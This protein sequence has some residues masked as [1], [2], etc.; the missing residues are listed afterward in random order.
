MWPDLECT[1]AVEADEDAAAMTSDPDHPNDNHLH[2][3]PQSTA[4]SPLDLLKRSAWI[5]DFLSIDFDSILPF[6]V[7]KFSSKDAN[8]TLIYNL[9]NIFFARLKIDSNTNEGV[10]AS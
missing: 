2:D 9:I 3:R 8:V 6:L 5:L 10:T 7:E 4:N 1:V